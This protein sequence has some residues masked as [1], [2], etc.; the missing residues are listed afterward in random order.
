MYLRND[1][2]ILA[3]VFQKFWK[4]CLKAYKLDPVDFFSTPNLS[5]D[6][7]LFITGVDLG[8]LSD[9]DMLLFF[10]RRI[11][12]GINGI[13]ELRHFRANNR[14][15]DVFDESKANVFGAFFD[16]TS[17]YAGTMQQTLPVVEFWV[18]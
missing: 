17:L 13:G 10:E 9:I 15:L 11:R 3:D 7:M 4:V 8:L 16:V 12:G 18:D 1:V 5:W 6:A 2:L 14:D